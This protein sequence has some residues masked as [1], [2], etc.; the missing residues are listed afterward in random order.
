M[1]EK[2]CVVRT[3]LW[4]DPVFDQLL[5]GNDKVELRIIDVNAPE[6]EWYETLKY[7]HY[8]H[9]SAAKDELP[10]ELFVTE[11]LLAHCPRLKGVS[12]LSAA[13]SLLL[14]VAS[15]SRL[16]SF[17]AYSSVGGVRWAVKIGTWDI[18]R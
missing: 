17:T 18:S 1:S 11:A 15:F 3:N 2:V 13:V 5:T 12:S 14:W 10:A 6:Q 16:S 8:Y 4:I 9:V 7:A